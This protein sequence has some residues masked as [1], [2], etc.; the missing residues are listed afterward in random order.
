MWGTKSNDKLIQGY[1]IMM[2]LDVPVQKISVF[3]KRGYLTYQGLISSSN[4][5]ITVTASKSVSPEI[6]KWDFLKL[7]FLSFDS[8]ISKDT[9]HEMLT[10]F[11]RNENWFYLKERMLLYEVMLTNR[12]SGL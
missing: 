6:N 9:C 5:W 11:H 8:A 4:V 10:L 2:V 1:T 7:I 3:R 12:S